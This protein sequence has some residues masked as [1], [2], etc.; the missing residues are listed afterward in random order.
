MQP[1][2]STPAGAILPPDFNVLDI[3]KSFSKA[4][5]CGLSGLCI[6]LSNATEVHLPTPLGALLRDL[7]NFLASGRGSSIFILNQ[8]N[9]RLL[10]HT[11]VVGHGCS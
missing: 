6:Q 5:A 1:L 2:V 4:T 3:L 10:L 11:V 7:I 8:L 9:S